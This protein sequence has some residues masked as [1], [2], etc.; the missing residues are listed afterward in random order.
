M[1]KGAVRR[2]VHLDGEIRKVNTVDI[3]L[4]Y[5][6]NEGGYISFHICTGIRFILAVSISQREDFPFGVELTGP[7]G[8]PLC[9]QALIRLC[10]FF[11]A[12]DVY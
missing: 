9:I 3:W 5:L 8:P 7:A 4:S 11:C 10:F 1:I 2:R 6:R 12:R